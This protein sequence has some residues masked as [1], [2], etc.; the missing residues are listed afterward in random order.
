MAGTAVATVKKALYDD[1]KALTAPG[2]PLEKV[3]VS[4]G[5]PGAPER[6][7][8][9]FGRTRFEHELSSFATGGGRQPRTEVA[10]ITAVILVRNISSDQYEGDARA[11]AIGTV[12][13]DMLAADPTMGGTVQLLRVESG[14]LSTEADDH[15]VITCLVYSVT[16]QSELI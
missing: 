2:Q 3:Q 15:G 1:L 8:L 11:I 9:Y 5:Y 12:L 4:Y 6:S 16:V 7:S 10:T 14:E 13:E